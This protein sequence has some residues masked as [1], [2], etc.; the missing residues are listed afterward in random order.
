MIQITK[1]N[2]AGNFAVPC[3]RR[4]ADVDAGKVHVCAAREQREREHERAR[5]R[6]DAQAQDAR[7]VQPQP[8]HQVTPQQGP[9]PPRRDRRK[10]C[11]AK[12]VRV[13]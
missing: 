12:I 6:H 1:I 3:M 8:L 7:A 13:S 5:G 9:S 2:D 4:V 11:T 10:A